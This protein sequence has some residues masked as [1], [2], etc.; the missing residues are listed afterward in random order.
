LASKCLKKEYI[1]LVNLYI[2]GNTVVDALLSVSDQILPLPIKYNGSKWNLDEKIK[3]ILITGHRR[4]NFGQ[5]F[6]NI[7]KAIKDLA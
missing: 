1:L 7:F 6:I 3:K 5:D 4:E 2:T